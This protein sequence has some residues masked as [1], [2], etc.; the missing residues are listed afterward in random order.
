MIAG[1]QDICTQLGNYDDDINNMHEKKYYNSA[2]SA[3][4]LERNTKYKQT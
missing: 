2:Q 3:E 1:L 4:N